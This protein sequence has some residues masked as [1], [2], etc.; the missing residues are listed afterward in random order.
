MRNRISKFIGTVLLAAAVGIPAAL[1]MNHLANDSA[2]ALVSSLDS[3]AHGDWSF[4]SL[5]VLPQ[6]NPTNV[7]TFYDNTRTNFTRI[8]PTNG[9]FWLRQ[10]GSNSFAA[11]VQT[12]NPALGVTN[13]TTGK[14]LVFINGLYVG[15]Q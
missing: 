13:N 7:V 10:Q 1:F 14:V 11:G 15:S 4:S 5:N 3:A 6:D 2:Y 12:A 9:G 8:N